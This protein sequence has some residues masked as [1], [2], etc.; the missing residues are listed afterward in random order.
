MRLLWV[1]PRFGTASV[2][3]AEALVRG[4]ATRA[5]PKGWESEVATT[6]ATD[7][8]TWENTLEPGTK[9]EDG[10]RVRRFRVGE[11]DPARYAE[12]H[13]TIFSGEAGYAAEVEWLANSVWSPEL[14]RFLEERGPDYDVV[15]FAPYLFGTTVWGVQAWPERS[16][17]LPC[18]HDEPYAYL[19]TVRRIVRGVRGCL[20]NSEAE[21]QL[22]GRLYGVDGPVVGM[23]FDPP[24]GPPTASF[25]GPRGLD[26]YLLYA[27]RIEEGKRVDVA[28]EYALRYAR[29]RPAAPKLV[30]VGS[31]TYRPPASARNIVV[32]AGFVDQDELRAAYAE[33]LA[34]VNPSRMESLSLVVMEGWL[35]GTPAIAAAGSDVLR[36]HCEASGGGFLFDSYEGYCEAVDLLVQDRSLRDRV[37]AAGR[38][39][40]LE[41]YCWPAVRPRFE[42]AIE[43]L[44][45]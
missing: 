19:A 14:G 6:C 22:A 43:R 3:G 42:E 2:G 4:L 12:L 40:V 39:Y 33:A 32:E 8:V 25:A 26:G 11:R 44:A 38:A 17:L 30:L 16:V 31:G 7:H 23:G 35:E 9:V 15:I 29:E 34:V 10:V 45:A 13:A 21:R 41:R 36:D 28:V 27:G 5:V 37:G 20:F 1:V 18:L 24:T